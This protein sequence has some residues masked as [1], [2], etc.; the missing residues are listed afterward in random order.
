MKVLDFTAFWAGPAATAWLAAM[1]ADVIKVEAVQRP[2]GIRFSA[3]V[4]PQ[5]EPMFYEMSALFHASNLG[6]RG[7]T[8]DLGH[9]DGLD[10]ARRLIARCDV[11]VENFTPRVLEQF[12]LD[13]EGVRALRPDAVM[14]RM[15]AFGLS[16]PWR[17]RPGFAQTMEQITGMAWVTGY[18]GGPPI[19]PGG[20][21]DP[22]VGTHT[23]L[24]IVAALEHRGAHGRRTTRRGSAP[25]SCD[26]RHRRPGHPLRR[27]TAR[28]SIGAVPAVSTRWPATTRGSRSTSRPTRCRP[29]RA[30]SGARRGTRRRRSPNCSRPAFPPRRWCPDTRRSTIRSCERAGSSSRRSTNTSVSRS[31]RRGRC[32]C[33]PGLRRYWTGPAPTLGQHTDEVLREELGVADEELDRLRA[34][35]VIGTVPYFG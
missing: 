10:L 27:S 3:T 4:R 23:A 11:I 24:A 29:K 33:R 6:K 7:I 31:T 32:A 15:P 16:G 17:D 19:I 21:V 12:G 8:L 13:Y 22:M 9:P 5:Q 20:P 28:C 30:P 2:D 35:H 18:E 1:G 25:R 14:V 26:R 34:E